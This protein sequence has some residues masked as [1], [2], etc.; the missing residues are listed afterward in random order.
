M[1]GV[2]SL[3][4]LSV[5]GQFLSSVATS[6]FSRRSRRR[7]EQPQGSGRAAVLSST[8]WR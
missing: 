6:D 5:V 7:G 2:I 4:F 8:A 1:E 3:G